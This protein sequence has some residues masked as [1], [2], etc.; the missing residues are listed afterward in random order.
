MKADFFIGNSFKRDV[1]LEAIPPI[2]TCIMHDGVC[3]AV[4]LNIALHVELSKWSIFC[5]I[6]KNRKV[7]EVRERFL[8]NTNV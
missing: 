3:I 8:E 2:G 4:V 5:R 1:E 7:T 6:N